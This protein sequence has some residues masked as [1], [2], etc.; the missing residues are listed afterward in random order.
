MS[1]VQS[2]APLTLVTGHED[3][4]TAILWVVGA[5]DDSTADS[6]ETECKRVAPLRAR[7]TRWSHEARCIGR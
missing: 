5:L 6:F 1:G 2:S 4:H 7:D 3:A